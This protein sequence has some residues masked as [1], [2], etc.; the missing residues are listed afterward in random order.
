MQAHE[1][2]S[3]RTRLLVGDDGIRRLEQLNVLVM[4][5]GGVGSWCVEALARSGVGQMTLV[6][7]DTVNT[8]NINRQIIALQTT[9][10]RPKVQIMAERVR[11]INPACR[12][13]ALQT[14]YTA[15][16][17]D[18]FDLDSFDY[19]VD[20]IDSL[21]D[22]V[23]LILRVTASRATLVSSMGAALKS[24]PTRIAISNFWDVK[25]CPL[26]RALRQRFKRTQQ[27]PKR[28]FKC[29]YS[30]ELLQNKRPEP[31]EYSTSL[32]NGSLIQATATFGLTLASLI[33]TPR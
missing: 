22:K 2:F 24:D 7:S 16:T 30:P 32:P 8:S 3:D 20:A 11:D 21:A 15:E 18:S 1:S 12:V 26:A 14:R 6:D 4:G 27:F 23:L 13:K 29:V 17:A 19:V 28:K 9:I 33:I 31:T 25:G 5:V 10:G